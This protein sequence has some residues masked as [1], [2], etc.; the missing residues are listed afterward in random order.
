MARFTGMEC[1]R[2]GQP[3]PPEGSP[4]WV[5]WESSHEGGW[6]CEYCLTDEVRDQSD[7]A[8]LLDYE[9]EMCGRWGVP[10]DE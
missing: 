8:L 6:L 2:C 10:P 4:D 1:Q 9:P 5:D 7:L 3:T